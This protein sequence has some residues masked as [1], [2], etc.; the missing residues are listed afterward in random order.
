MTFLL[1]IKMSPDVGVSCP[2]INLRVV[3]FPQ[4]EGPSRQ[5]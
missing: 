3:D 2:A 5:Q 1:L 4:P